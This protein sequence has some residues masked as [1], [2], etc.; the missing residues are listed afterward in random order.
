MVATTVEAD[1]SFQINSSKE[2]EQFCI[3]SL[4]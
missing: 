3:T 2:E 4:E 1:S